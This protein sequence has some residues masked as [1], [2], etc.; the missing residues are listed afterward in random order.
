MDE[1]ALLEWLQEKL[2]TE[3]GLRKD[4][5]TMDANL[6]SDLAFDSLDAVQLIYEL[7]DE[8]DVMIPPSGND[9][10]ADQLQTVGDAIR[11]ILPQLNNG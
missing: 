5:I 4:L 7:E 3:Y 10:D 8:F 9:A 1:D 11:M 2:N 6:F